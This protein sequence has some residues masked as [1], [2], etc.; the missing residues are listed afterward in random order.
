MR[1]LAD[2]SPY[3]PILLVAGVALVVWRLR[4]RVPKREDR[5]PILARRVEGFQILSPL[6]PRMSRTCIFDFGLQ[7]GPG[8][9]RKDGPALPHSPDCRC[10]AEPFAFTSSEVFSGAL[11]RLAEAGTDLPGFP[12]E[13][14]K[15]LLDALRRV[16]ADPVPETLKAYL[17]ATGRDDFPAEQRAAVGRFLTERFEFLI[18]QEH[19]PRAAGHPA[20]D[21]ANP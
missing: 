12:Q 5:A 18:G 8:F 1:A 10:R 6:H 4:R 20:S 13:A 17:A 19:R 15:P 7:Y 21:P 2:L 16:N 11:R 3:W 14:C 9:R